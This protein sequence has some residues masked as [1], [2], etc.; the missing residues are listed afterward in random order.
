MT[1]SEI[2]QFILYFAVII[3]LT[4]LLGGYMAR[5]FSGKPVVL[6]PLVRPLERMVYRFAGV[7][8]T[9]EMT[10]RGYAAALLVFNI[11][12]FIVVLLLQLFQ[13]ALPLNPAGVGNVEPL[14]SFN[15][16]TSFMTNTNWQAYGGETTLSY[17]TQMAGLTVQ[18][19]LSAATG[20]AVL[21]AL[22][23]GIVAKT[24]KSLGNFWVDMV[25]AT[26][27]VLL[28]LSLLWA[29]LLVGQGIPQN[30]NP[31][32]AARSLSGESQYIPQGPVASQIAIKQLGTNG[33]GYFN[34][35]STHPYE[36][37]TPFSN[38][39]EMV[40]LLLIPAALTH[41][42]GLMV[43]SVRQGWAIFV[44]MLILFV[45]GLGV[46]LLAEYSPNPVYKG[47]S[48]A[49]MEGK[50]TRFGVANSI[51]WGAATTAASNGAVNAMHSSFSP[52]AGGIAL[53]NMLF[54]EVIFGG[55]GAGLYGMLIFVILTVFLA[56]LMVNARI[57][58][59]KD[60]HMGGEVGD[61]GGAAAKRDDPVIHCPRQPHYCG[62]IQPRQ[63]R[64][65]W[66][67]RNALCLCFLRG[68]QWERLCRTE[69]QHTV[70]QPAD[71]DFYVGGALRDDSPRAGD[72]RKFGRKTGY[73][74]LAGDVPHRWG[75][76]CCVAHC[77]DRHRWRVDLL[78]RLSARPTCRTLPD[79]RRAGVLKR[80]VSEVSWKTRQGKRVHL[81]IGQ[82]CEGR[83]EMPCGNS[84]PVNW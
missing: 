15:T 30:F 60:H 18:N 32:T 44:A 82:C 16:A 66:V 49:L 14:L 83:W 35:N 80:E 71:R 47:V 72:W 54:G 55:V 11:L 33:G 46:M 76:L 2:I 28:P 21:I 70:L 51:L 65:A 63:Q 74:A 38:F 68:E 64:G 42:Y 52:L 6:S 43:G 23:R 36:N 78:P 3:A 58:G 81:L 75:A 45:I 56:G 50:E 73:A 59:E 84:P 34:T 24:G 62:V 31:Y 53:L 9:A 20:I 7:N 1:P 19:V 37:P 57:S 39:L 27:Y 4:P 77:G 26:L 29:V 41:T 48:A 69:R 12:G 25:R 79:E 40:A 10:W 67:F 5:V 22:T 8:P 17:L 61:H 13:S